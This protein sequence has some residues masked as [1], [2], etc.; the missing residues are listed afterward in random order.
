MFQAR[1]FGVSARSLRLQASARESEA[2]PLTFPQDGAQA[3]SQ[4][5]TLTLSK[6]SASFTPSVTAREAT[7]PLEGSWGRVA[8]RGGPNQSGADHR[9][10]KSIGGLA[11]LRKLRNARRREHL[12]N[13]TANVVAAFSGRRLARRGSLPRPLP[14]H[15]DTS[16][17]SQLSVYGHGEIGSLVPVQKT[18]CAG[19]SSPKLAPEKSCKSARAMG[20][21]SGKCD[22]PG[23]GSADGSFTHR[24]SQ[25]CTHI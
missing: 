25:L 17:S 13:R 6:E 12:W 21:S 16:A 23:R 2:D 1:S 10:S 15:L 7:Q 24:G 5:R 20:K 4:A 11:E 18:R 19:G 3:P 14:P 9:P 22:G 8:V